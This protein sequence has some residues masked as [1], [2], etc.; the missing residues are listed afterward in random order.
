MSPQGRVLLSNELVTELDRPTTSSFPRPLGELASRDDLIT[1][2]TRLLFNTLIPGRTEPPPCN[3]RL[4]HNLVAFF[5]MLMYLSRLGYPGHWL[6][7]FVA[8]ILSGRMVSDIPP[9][10]GEYPIAVEERTRRVP[11]PT[12]RTDPWL[13]EFEAV[14]ATAYYAIPFPISG[15]LPPDFS[16]ISDDITIWEDSVQLVP[17][18]F[19]GKGLYS[20]PYEP[21]AQLLFY[22]FD[23]LTAREVIENMHDI[24]EGKPTP[25]PGLFFLLTAPEHVVYWDMVR[26]RLSRQR[27]DRMRTTNGAWSRT[28]TTR[29]CRRRSRLQPSAG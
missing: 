28:V 3:I 15:A 29:A 1:W 26:F 25:L 9:Y 18:F 5:G 2:L 8:R 12:V 23:K 19:P 11:S 21:R 14:S 17:S 7:A 6:S 4:P 10:T 20:N 24:F 22:R 16:S 27:V 13:V